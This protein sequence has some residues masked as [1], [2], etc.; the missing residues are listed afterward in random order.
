MND[1][2]LPKFAKQR[3]DK[4]HQLVSGALSHGDAGGAGYLLSLKMAADN[5]YRVI[6][7]GAYFNLSD[8]H[9]QPT[10]S[11]WNNLKKRLKRREPRLFIFKE[12]G[13]IECPKKH[14]VSQKCFYIDIGYF[15]E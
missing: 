15:A 9:P 4:V 14:A 2:T 12:Y 1:H 3:Y 11:Q 8:E 10:K 5:H 6:F 7:S 13:E